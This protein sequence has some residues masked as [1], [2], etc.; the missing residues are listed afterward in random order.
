MI[1]CIFFTR[2]V[3]L[4]NWIE[5]GIF[6]REKLIYEHYLNVMEVKKIYWITYGYSDEILAE[7]LK[8]DGE[9]HQS[10]QILCAPKILSDTKLG[11]LIYSLISPV[12]HG[13]Y[14]KSCDVMKTNQMDGGWSALIAKWLYEKPLFARTGYTLSKSTTGYKKKI[15]AIIEKIIFRSAD[16]ISVTSEEDKYYVINSYNI[17][18]IHVIPNFVNLSDFKN[19]QYNRDESKVLYVG[20]LNYEK[21]L[22]NLIEC[23]SSLKLGLILYGDGTIKDKLI[24]Y[25]IK[26]N[27]NVEFKGSIKNNEL[28]HVYNSYRFYVLPSLREGMPKTLMEAMSC[29]CICIGT[30]VSGI[31][32]LIKEGVTGYLALNT[33]SSELVAAF[34]R[35][36]SMRDHLIMSESETFIKNTFALEKVAQLEFG[37]ISELLI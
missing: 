26:H 7:R 4:K 11:S 31:R 15:A 6:Y 5:T 33:T 16:L 32:E 24:S 8:K 18:S 35:A 19:L 12:F 20:R 34:R 27:V 22:F 1:L 36:V 25:A 3:S 13:K 28:S 10:I 17:R 37:L 9:L 29:G 21:N 23:M 2:G 30:N 14:I